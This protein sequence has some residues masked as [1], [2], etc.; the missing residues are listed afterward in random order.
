MSGYSEDL[1]EGRAPE[2]RAFL[3]KP[4][5]PRDLIA[6]VGAQLASPR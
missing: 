2:A 6:F 1:L 4:F 5:T 3:A